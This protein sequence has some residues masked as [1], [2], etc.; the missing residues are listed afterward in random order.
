[1]FELTG[2]MTHMLPVLLGALLGAAVG[3]RFNLSVYDT[4]LSLRGLPI[5]PAVQAKWH[6][7]RASDIMHKSGLYITSTMTYGQ[8]ASLLHQ[9]TEETHSVIPVVSDFGACWFRFEVGG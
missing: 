6:S 5:L 2:Q 9:S 7:K 8:V 1:V 4:M 3:N